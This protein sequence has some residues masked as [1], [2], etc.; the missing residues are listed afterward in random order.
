INNPLGIV[1]NY[2]ELLKLRDLDPDAA[3]KLGKIENEVNRIEKIVGSLLSF[4]KVDDASFQDVD[5]AEILEEVLL[6]LAHR[7]AEKSITVEKRIPAGPVSVRGDQNKLKQLFLNLLTNSIEAVPDAGGA[8]EAAVASDA[9]ARSAEI[10]ITD[11]GCGIPDDLQGRIFD[12][13][14]STKKNRKN[15]GLGLSISQRIVELHGGMMS[16]TSRPGRFTR[17]SVRFP[18]A[19]V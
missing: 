4:S 18:L 19:G 8:V 13:F 14:F 17:F 10:A 5:L 16:C 12:P 7:F 11:N 1:R 9:E 3:V 6:L 15:A 2:V